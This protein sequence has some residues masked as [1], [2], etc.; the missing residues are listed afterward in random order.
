M[1]LKGKEENLIKI[2][3]ELIKELT[4]AGALGVEANLYAESGFNPNNLQNTSNKRLNMTDEEYVTAVDNGS[5]TNFVKDSAGFGLAQWTYW[6]RKQALLQY[7]QSGGKSIGDLYMQVKHLLM[8]LRQKKSLYKLLTS[9]DNCRKCAIEVMLQYERPA[10]Q[11]EKAQ[12]V[13]AD[14]A[15]ELYEYFK[16][17][18]VNSVTE[19]QLREQIINIAVGWLGCKESDGSHKQIIDTYNAHTPRARGYKVKYTD[20]WCATFGS[21]VAIKAGLTDIIPTECGCEKQIALF[22]ALGSWQENDTYTPQA[23]DYIFYDW[24][25]N[26]VGDNTGRSDHVGIV[27]ALNGSTIKIIEGNYKNSVCYREIAVNGK[28]IRGYGVPKYSSLARVEEG[29]KQEVKQETTPSTPTITEQSIKVGDTVMFTGS[30]HYT[31]SFAK[32]T[33]R[34]CKAG[35]AKVTAI[36]AGKPHPY[37]LKAVVGKGATVYGWVNA[38]DVSAVTDTSNKTYVIKRGDTLSKIAKKYNTTVNKLASLNGIKNPSLIRVGQI[39]KL[40]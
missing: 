9:S 36:S 30:L 10:N 7:A 12:Q 23:G 18:E 13:R 37:H 19:K 20:A 24:Q 17:K 16:S 31:S 5:Y 6:S 2:H 34:G 25:D 35:L 29:V 40:P 26:G 32:A 8:E 14:Y 38:N 28:Y 27:V 11:S 3:N 39:I 1:N 15:T 33:A 4:L 21:A 22:K